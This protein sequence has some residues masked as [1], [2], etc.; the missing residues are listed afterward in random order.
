MVLTTTDLNIL[1]YNIPHNLIQVNDLLKY[2]IS[3]LQMGTLRLH[4]L[5]YL[6][7]FKKYVC[8]SIRQILPTVEQCLS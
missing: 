3:S 8:S 1:L 7:K 4:R 6:S 2:T 5:S